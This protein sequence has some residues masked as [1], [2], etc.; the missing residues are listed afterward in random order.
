VA[1]NKQIGLPDQI[2]KEGVILRPTVILGTD[3]G[4]WRIKLDG[5]H[6]PDGRI[7]RPENFEVI[8][9]GPEPK[10]GPDAAVPSDPVT[11]GAG[12]AFAAGDHVQFNDAGDDGVLKTGV[13]KNW[14]TNVTGN[15][16]EEG[17]P[18]S[19]G[20][21]RIEVDGEGDAFAVEGDVELLDPAVVDYQPADPF[22][23]GDRVRIKSN[24]DA[25]GEHWMLGREGTV[26]GTDG[27]GRMKQVHVLGS[28]GEDDTFPFKSS[29]LELLDSGVRKPDFHAGDYVRVLGNGN[30]E[31]LRGE[32][33]GDVVDPIGG[34]PVHNVKLD[35]APNLG[36]GIEGDTV[37]IYDSDLVATVTPCMPKR[38]PQPT[39]R[40]SAA[41]LQWATR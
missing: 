11:P 36:S 17:N 38:S 5:Q 29:E 27:R 23:T 19:N 4:G 18:Q 10:G 37:L 35:A 39:P 12:H 16:D 28:G 14:T 40:S 41:I 26:L 33:Q 7:V 25:G 15:E 9:D 30:H 24:A 20:G 32:V 34:R 13:L 31:G 3:V 6:G 8:Q 22:K 1:A 21:W 2:G